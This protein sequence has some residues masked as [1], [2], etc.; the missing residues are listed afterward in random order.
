MMSLNIQALTRLGWSAQLQQ[1]LSFEEMEQTTP[2]RIMAVHRG[3]LELSNG[4]EEQVIPV[5]DMLL[6]EGGQ[7]QVTA[8]DWILVS[9]D[10]GDF[11]RLLDRFSLIQRQS[12]GTL[13]S[14]QMVGAN[15]DTMFI[16][17]SCNDDFN[18]SRLERYLA[19]AH[20]ADVYPVIVLTKRDVANDPQ[21]Y[22]DM[23]RTLGPNILV[24]LINA[25]DLATMSGLQD[26]CKPG[27]TIAL[28]GS[29]GVG[30]STLANTL[31]AKPQK[32]GG[33]REDDAKGR[34]TTTHRSLHPLSNGAVLMDNPGMRGLGMAGIGAGVA[35]VFEDIDEYSQKCRFSDCSH[36]QEP[37]CA[38]RA[39]IENNELSERRLKNY[40]K[41]MAEQERNAASNAERRK[42]DKATVNFHKNVQAHKRSKERL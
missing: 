24:E 12:A 7:D 36:D 18:L 34:H 11:V 13:K 31:G 1:Q 28:V 26:L 23:A 33:I 25:H 27:Q 40:S 37:G 21:S 22:V 41:L 16:V 3:R 19:I 9:N 14:Q 20:A 10:S 32:T 35:M 15:V 39:A 8:G 30:K 6:Q 42:K 38:V 2:C 5:A 4:E 29:S 17:S